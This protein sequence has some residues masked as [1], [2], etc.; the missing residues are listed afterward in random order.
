MSENLV[1]NKISEKKILFL[2]VK[3]LFKHLSFACSRI[4]KPIT[5]VR[6][7]FSKGLLIRKL[8]FYIKQYFFPK[9]K[10]ESEPISY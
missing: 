5:E 9:E 7:T 4:I 2:G 6:K 8:D 10:K 3:I 1:F